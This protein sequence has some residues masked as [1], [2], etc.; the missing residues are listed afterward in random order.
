M[1]DLSRPNR[2]DMSPKSS[3][4][5][6]RNPGRADAARLRVRRLSPRD[7]NPRSAHADTDPT[8]T[9]SRSNGDP[10]SNGNPRSDCHSS[11][12][13]DSDTGPHTHDYA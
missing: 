3:N 12:D 10:G 13:R 6:L 5:L 7:A 2:R 9:D 1:I 11:A 4:S 8:V